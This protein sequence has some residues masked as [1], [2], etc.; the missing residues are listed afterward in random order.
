M[1]GM[2]NKNNV[3]T[4]LSAPSQELLD[5]QRRDDL[6][7]LLSDFSEDNSIN[8]FGTIPPAHGKAHRV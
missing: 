3:T 2:T 8:K 6:F 7:C 4:Y 1:K 5:L